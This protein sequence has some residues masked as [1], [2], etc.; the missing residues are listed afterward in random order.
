MKLADI[1]FG[2]WAIVPAMLEEIQGIYATHLRGEKIDIKAIE[3]A[4]GYSMNSEQRPYDIQDGI[5]IIPIQGTIS[6]KMNFF[7]SI[8]GGASSQ[9]IARDFQQALADPA[10]TGIIFDI[11]SPGGTVSGTAELASMIADSRGQKPVCAITDGKMCSAAY[12]IASA[13][14]SLYITSDTTAVGSIGVVIKHQDISGQE[15]QRGIKTTILT[16]GQYKGVGHPHAPLSEDH[17]NI[18]QANLDYLYTAFVNAVA[19]NRSIPAAQVIDTMAEGRIFTGKQAIT[20][21]LVDG[22]STL[23]QLI[24]NMS[25]GIMPPKNNPSPAPAGSAGAQGEEIMNLIELKEKHPDIYQAVVTEG[26]AAG[27]AMEQVRILA[28][29][30]NALPGHDA[31]VQQCITEGVSADAAA[32][33]ILLAEKSKLDAAAADFAA[34]GANPVPVAEGGEAIQEAAEHASVVSAAVAAGNIGR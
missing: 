15:A 21:G 3:A 30:T 1:V 28:I 11:N 31:L 23:D 9:L 34:G 16:A 18:I 19:A 20:A 22:V 17:Q 7:S 5:A 2:P 13:A 26:M 24:A 12:W 8:C 14:D 6:Q 27:A 25:G 33:K 32:G 29:Q 4:A 10:V